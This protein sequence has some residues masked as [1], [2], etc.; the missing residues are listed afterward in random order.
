MNSRKRCGV[1]VAAPDSLGITSPTIGVLYAST[2][3]RVTA[4]LVVRH[5][6]DAHFPD[7]LFPGW[8]YHPFL[9]NTDLPVEQADITQHVVAKR[10]PQVDER[11]LMETSAHRPRGRTTRVPRRDHDCRAKGVVPDLTVRR[12][13]R[14]KRW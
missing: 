6:K 11:H 10:K 5:V 13:Y 2:P 1:H 8:R 14:V 12:G 3:D 7:A 4:R 9:T